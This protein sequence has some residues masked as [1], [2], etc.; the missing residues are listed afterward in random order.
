VQRIAGQSKSNEDNRS[1]SP[2]KI[3]LSCIPPKTT[4]H[5]K[6]IVRVKGFARLA[7][8]PELTAAKDTYEA[9]LCQ[10]QIGTPYEGF[11]SVVIEVTWPWR[12]DTPKY[13]RVLGRV[14][15]NT[16]PDADDFAKTLIDSLVR[17]RFIYEDSQVSEL[18]VRKFWGDVPGVAIE[19]RHLDEDG[20]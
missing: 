11:L 14:R 6:R 18:V 4:H 5:A 10:H 2:C 9:L 12:K 16:K 13:K 20:V 15:C 3:F 8:K 7:D 19:I 1:D 17:M